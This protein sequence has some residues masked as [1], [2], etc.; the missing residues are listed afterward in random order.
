M[1][2]VFVDS[3]AFLGLLVPEDNSHS[4]AKGLFEQA[5]A[6]R[7]TLVTT[8]AVVM[9]SYSLFLVRT[10]DRR[11]SALAFLDALKQDQVRIE[12]IRKQDEEQAVALV[13]AHDDKT[14]SLCDALSFAVMERL[15]IREAIAFDRHFR[16]YGQFTIL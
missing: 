8:N 5:K 16:E 2:R 10:R 13:R 6:D 12:R 3:S 11:R 15:G 7:W 9:E 4:R 1:K 14:Y